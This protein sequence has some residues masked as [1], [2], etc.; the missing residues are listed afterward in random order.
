MISLGNEIQENCSP[1][2]EK[3]GSE[4]AVLRRYWLMNM[5]Y[6][7]PGLKENTFN[8]LCLLSVLFAKPPIF[9]HSSRISGE[10]R[11]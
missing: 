10:K 8:F 4:Q 9:H 3:G 2:I 5:L 11:H 1:D 7:C 6:G